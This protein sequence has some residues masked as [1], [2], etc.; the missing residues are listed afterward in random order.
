MEQQMRQPETDLKPA[1]LG[2]P[3]LG[4]R[5]L[6]RRG[7]VSTAAVV[8]VAGLQ[9]AAAQ[10]SANPPPNVPEWMKTQG[11]GFLNPPYGLPSPFESKVVRRLP[12][13]PAA[14]PTA[15]RTP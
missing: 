9:S 4:R 7:A 13:V 15:T 11:T 2:S 3:D 6:L 12:A 1:D 14:F 5:S 8:G 10:S